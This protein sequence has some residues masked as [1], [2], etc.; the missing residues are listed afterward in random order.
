MTLQKEANGALGLS[1]KA[2]Q[3]CAQMLYDLKLSTY[4]RA[5][6]DCLPEDMKASR[7]NNFAGIQPSWLADARPTAKKYLTPAK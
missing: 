1:A 7:P 4:A 5:D 2:A 3:D 6:N